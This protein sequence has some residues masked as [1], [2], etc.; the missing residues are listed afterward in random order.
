MD[1]H[2]YYFNVPF[3]VMTVVTAASCFFFAVS[4]MAVMSHEKIKRFDKIECIIY[5]GQEPKIDPHI[6]GM[7][8]V[9]SLEAFFA[10]K[11]GEIYNVTIYSHPPPY[12]V[13]QKSAKKVTSVMNALQKKGRVEVRI[14]NSLQKAYSQNVNIRSWGSAL[15]VSI[16]ILF[17]SVVLWCVFF[18]DHYVNSSGKDCCHP[19]VV[20]FFMYGMRMKVE[21]EIQLN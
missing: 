21:P 8:Y 11:K 15:F 1:I 20:N 16:V 10:S 4:I 18:F 13:N 12:I 6:S 14:N 19:T 5:E 9:G 7:G 3:L 2:K 17:V